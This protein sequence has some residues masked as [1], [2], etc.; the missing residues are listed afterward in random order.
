MAADAGIAAIVLAGGRGSRLQDRD[1]GLILLA[2][3]PL[4]GWVVERL[5]PQTTELVLSANR[6]LDAY[7]A[8]GCPVVSDDLPGQPGPLAGILAASAGVGRE[9]LLVAPCDTPFLPHDLADRLLA[10][11]QAAGVLLARAADPRR[12]HYAVVLLHRDLLADMRETMAAGERSLRGWQAR[13]RHAEVRFESAQ[14]FLNINTAADL[15]HAES[16]VGGQIGVTDAG[17]RVVH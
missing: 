3:R 6:N 17:Q 4:A 12:S 8:L 5:R 9:W 2:G 7:R 1:K 16:I 13:H 11:A 10:A 14:H 15:A